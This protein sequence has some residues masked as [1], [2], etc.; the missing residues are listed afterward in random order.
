MANLSLNVY[1]VKW[2]LTRYVDTEKTSE[3]TKEHLLQLVPT[4]EALATSSKVHLIQSIVSRIFVNSIFEEYFV[5][6]P[7]EQADQL[8]NIEKYLGGF[9]ELYELVDLQN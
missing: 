4:Y 1:T 7:K 2:N 6:I 5:G 9:G 8:K 3:V